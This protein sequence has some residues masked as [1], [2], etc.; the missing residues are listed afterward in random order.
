MQPRTTSRI[1]LTALVGTRVSI[2]GYTVPLEMK[3]KYKHFILSEKGTTGAFCPPGE[4]YEI[5][6]VESRDAVAWSQEP[7]TVRGTFG[8]TENQTMG[9]FFILK[10]ANVET[11]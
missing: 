2:T 1:S 10:D 6:E 8:L 11:S 7:V 9:L 4:P 3:E 5:V